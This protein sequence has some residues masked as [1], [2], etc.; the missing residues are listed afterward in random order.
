[1]ARLRAVLKAVSTAVRRDLKSAGSF[2][3]NNLFVAA[4]TFLFFKDPGAFVALNVIICLG[5]FIPLSA[6][7]LRIVPRDRLALW[8]LRTGERR[9]LRMLSPWLSPVTWFVAVLA[10]WRRISLGLF[11][12][13]AM[14]YA[15]GFVLPTMSGVRQGMW[16]RMPHFP[17]RLD[18]LVRKNLRQIL[19]TLDFWCAAMLSAGALGFRLAGRLPDDALLPLTIL[20]MLPYSTGAQT[21]F[22]L[23]GEG[24]LT[25]YALLPVPNWQVLVAK[26]A[27]F[28]LSAAFLVAPLAPVGGLAAALAA[29]ALGHAT[30]VKR[31]APQSRW[32]FSSGAGFGASIFQI[33]LMAMAA[34]AAH[35]HPWS[36]AVAAAA[37]AGSLAWYGR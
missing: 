23:D 31:D 16:R 29:L 18:Q 3:G 34:S 15:A 19:S 24:G 20:V 37:F 17:G 36:L 26:D 6:D 12:T 4:L 7:P 21:L 13:A 32:R 8:P 35:A 5:L 33:V 1:M 2:A 27:A 22:G 30:S 28:L 25:R 14:V 9:L 10:F 11:A